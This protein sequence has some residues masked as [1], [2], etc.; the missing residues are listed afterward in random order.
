MGG[1]SSSAASGG[2]SGFASEARLAKARKGFVHPSATGA[3]LPG[4]TLR[5]LSGHNSTH[6]V[7]GAIITG[8]S[9]TV[10]GCDNIIEG[11]CNKVFGHG[12]LIRG[13]ANKAEGSRNTVRGNANKLFGPGSLSAAGNA[14]KSDQAL[15][16]PERVPP[17][18]KAHLQQAP[19]AATPSVPVVQPEVPVVMGEEVVP[20][21]EPIVDGGVY[22]K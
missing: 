3:D 21:G 11:N 2:P 16:T 6:T 19:S 15:R 5:H 7:D 8:N 9:N 20:V 17:D 12:N 13:N 4:H 22:K 14:N 10:Y 18:P 1:V